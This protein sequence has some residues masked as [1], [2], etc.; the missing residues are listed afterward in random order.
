M[1]DAILTRR[2]ETQNNYI[3]IPSLA[4]AAISCLVF[5]IIAIALLLLTHR[6]RLR[7]PI[8]LIIGAACESIG[9][10]FRSLSASG[11][12]L[13]SFALFLLM[14]MF[15]I[16]SP[17]AFMAGL[18]VV[19]GRLIRRIT[20]VAGSLDHSDESSTTRTNV[21]DTT[22]QGKPKHGSTKFSP[23]PA[24]LY[25]R[26]FVI[27]DVISF[28]IQAG[29]AGLIVSSKP[30]TS[31]LGKYILLV[32]LAFGLASFSTFISLVLW[33]NL[34]VYK[35]SRRSNNETVRAIG[36]S[37]DWRQLMVPILIGSMCILVRTI[38]RLIE[39]AGGYSGHIYT[40]EWYLYVFDTTFMVICASIWIPLFP[41]RFG[42]S[43]F[44][45]GLESR[46]V[47][48]IEIASRSTEKS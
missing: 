18:Y 44:I 26:L 16:L 7:Y 1:Y 35:I 3:Y 43:Q 8:I 10:L 11:N 39:F 48:Q 13:E 36:L 9:Y 30:T 19:Y 15:V 20:T 45:T 2:N 6:Y 12:R 21:N 23:L 34:S 41:G 32:G 29:G 17:L 31:R 47:P 24:H 22:A 14:D 37:D 4:G 27:C 28:L 5:A 46:V 25:T 38:Y 33:F 40:T 42:L